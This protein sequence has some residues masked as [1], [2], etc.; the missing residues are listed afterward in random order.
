MQP[1][2]RARAFFAK[3][4]FAMGLTGIEIDEL[5]AGYSKCSLAICEK[6]LNSDGVVMGGALFTLADVA[7]AVA[8]NY[9]ANVVTLSSQI[10]FL[11]PATGARLKAEARLVH[12]GRSV[13]LYQVSVT[14]DAGDIVSHVTFNGF[15][16]NQRAIL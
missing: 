6:H 7:F 4:Q 9:D 1:I 12:K 10:N 14:N 15:V 16:K 2:D 3:D 8:A 5:E 11:R 13:C